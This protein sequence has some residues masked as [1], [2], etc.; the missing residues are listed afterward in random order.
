MVRVFRGPSA[1]RR[2]VALRT[3]SVGV[4]VG[5]ALALA[6]GPVVL[7][8]VL[9]ASASPPT[10]GATASAIGLSINLFGTEISGG[11][12]I[13]TVDSALLKAH[14]EGIGTLLTSGGAQL[15]D[16]SDASS[17]NTAQNAPW[18]CPKGGGT[19]SGTP[20]LIS[21]GAGCASSAAGVTADGWPTSSSQ[22]QVGELDVGANG[23]LQPVLQGGANQLTQG[24]ASGLGSCASSAGGNPVGQLCAGLSQAV[25]NLQNT[26][27]AAGS[28]NQPDIIVKLGTAV[29]SVTNAGGAGSGGYPLTATA[30]GDSADIQV[31]PGVGSIGATFANGALSGVLS[32]APLMEVKILPATATSIFDGKGWT[33]TS[34]S[35]VAII[36]LNIPGDVQTIDLNAPGQCQEF[37][38]GTPLDS[39]VCLAAASTSAG[40]AAQAHSVKASL[41]T[42]LPGA[43]GQ[44]VQLNLGDVSTNGIDAAT[45]AAG[46][47]TAASPP[48]VPAQVI[49]TSPTA[50]HTGEWWSGSLP[51]VAAAAALGG[52]LIGWPR[53]R[54]LPLVARVVGRTRR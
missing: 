46:P 12:A 26:V 8:G 10:Y 30:E 45:A 34:H 16:T 24:L 33:S 52:L 4:L 44:G 15:H 32:G 5:G 54:R 14:A 7:T 41:L 19:P 39:T 29:T 36:S 13:A 11:S 40:G 23:I 28:V 27:Q 47:P 1:T 42:A 9:P 17:N 43:P 51:V 37:A 38:A 21:I 25:T 49:G 35:S 22:G 3:G 31:L 18:S 2:R 50:V 6:G 20:L 53:L 48:A